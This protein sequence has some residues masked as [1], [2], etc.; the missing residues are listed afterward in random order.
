MLLSRA[1]INNGFSARASMYIFFISKGSLL[2]TGKQKALIQLDALELLLLDKN[3]K[4]ALQEVT[5]WIAPQAQSLSLSSCPYLEVKICFCMAPPCLRDSDWC[6]CYL[7][8]TS[9]QL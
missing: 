7:V 8:G 3:L 4:S 1:E 2:G 9:N 6:Y 5:L